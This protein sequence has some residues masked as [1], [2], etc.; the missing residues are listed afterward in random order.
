[1]PDAATTAKRLVTL[2]ALTA[3]VALVL[4][5][6]VGRHEFE[7]TILLGFILLAGYIAGSIAAGF[8]LPRVTGYVLV[9]IAVGPHALG[10]FSGEAV[11]SLRTIDELALALIALTAG[12]ELKMGPLRS[13]ARSIVGMGLGVLVV[14]GAYVL[15]LRGDLAGSVARMYTGFERLAH[16]HAGTTLSIFHAVQ[17]HSLAALG[18]HREAARHADLVRDELRRGSERYYWSECQRLLGDYL[19]LCPG[20]AA[21]A[22]ESAYAEALAT[23]GAQQAKTWELNAALSL[24]ALCAER[25]E[26]KRASDLLAPLRSGMAQQAEDLPAVRRSATLLDKLSRAQP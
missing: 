11:E 3:F 6:D 10:I 24:A 8:R 23:A 17:A 13:S 19:R 25:G 9:G 4:E 5:L 1:M 22:V 12:G 2:A 14:V 16:A 7:A 18:R 20:I 21:G 26:R 15:S